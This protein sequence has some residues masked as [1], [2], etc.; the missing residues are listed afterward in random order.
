VWPGWETV[1]LIGRGSFGGVYEIRR[2][3]FGHPEKAALK[4]IRIPQNDS[5]LDELRNDGYDNESI[6]E[7]FHS[8]L[9]DILREYAL[10]A[11]MKG[12]SNVVYCDDVRCIQHDN[13]IGW[14][15]FIKME[16]LTPLPQAL[17][18]TIPEE[19]VVRI[20]ADVCSA[21]SFCEKR[22]LIH[23]DIKPA[24]VFVA[25]DGTYKLGDFGIAKTAERTTSGT[26]TGTY[27]YMAPEVYNNQPY[28][29]K[30][31]IYSLG[32]VLYWL[33]N[34]R[35]T[36]FLPLPPVTPSA[37]VE[38]AARL[39][40]FRGEAI[41]A[42]AH[43]SAELQRIVLKA[44]AYD[45]AERYQSADEMLRDLRGLDHTELSPSTPKSPVG[46]HHDAPAD[47]TAPGS[48]ATVG[49]FGATIGATSGRP[50]PASNAD[51]PDATVGAGLVPARG[52]GQVLDQEKETNPE[53]KLH[54]SHE[55]DAATVKAHAGTRRKEEP[56]KKK[57]GLLIALL[58]AVLGVAALLMFLLLPHYGE[59][60]E[61][62]AEEP[63]QLDG[64]KIETA[65]GY[66][67]QEQTLQKTTD[68][69]E[70]VGEVD[71]EGV[72]LGAWGEW[73]EWQE[74]EIQSDE[75]TKVE[76]KTQ[77]RFR[78]KEFT[79]ATTDTLDGWELFD[80]ESES[81]WTAFSDWSPDP[82]YESD[83]RKVKTRTQ[84]RHQ[85]TEFVWDVTDP[86]PYLD[87]GYYVWWSNYDNRT[88]VTDYIMVKVSPWSEWSFEFDETTLNEPGERHDVEAR[89]V[90]SHSDL[91]TTTTY[92]F[93]RWGEWS[94]W[95]FAKKT[96]TDD[97]E[98]E[99][100]QVFRSK[101]KIEVPVYYYYDWSDWSDWSPEPIEESDTV[102]VET[103][104]IYRYAD[105]K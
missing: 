25:P 7:R 11:D 56:K 89:T 34:E 20:G 35:R 69:S 76:E 62:S 32:L 13:G 45:P 63:E 50:D 54:S 104:A 105:R 66:R 40:R 61:W 37:R 100:R 3:V 46:A 74:E 1:D 92:S 73:S 9:Q 36:P 70:V 16:L 47:T 22:N 24:N 83:T 98:V 26:K 43:G 42:P 95:S 85:D 65:I 5:E 59:W 4:Y 55:E 30:A 87:Q 99:N 57:K 103:R 91:I 79:T 21:L 39:R 49:V 15:I 77:Y 84:Y 60:S 86:T 58:A 2:D 80:S 75:N 81:H 48:D 8:Y 29:A 41:P 44:C 52:Q 72:E 78:E 68:R 93:Y 19:Q 23:R 94:D 12:C 71:H 51:N 31:D 67:Y 53:K 97:I 33:L 88:G 18:K 96:G 38:D 6:T 90:Y 17:G 64:R 101:S 10:M 27:K 82:V 28:G 14:D 102:Q